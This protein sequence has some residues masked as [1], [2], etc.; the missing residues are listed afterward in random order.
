[1]LLRLGVLSKVVRCGVYLQIST[2]SIQAFQH[3]IDFRKRSD[4]AGLSAMAKQCT[5]TRAY[6]CQVKSIVLDGTE[7]V[8]DCTVHVAHAYDAN[9]FVSH[10]CGEQFLHDGDVCNL[11]AI[12]LER[13]IRDDAI[14]GYDFFSDPN[15]TGPGKGD[16]VWGKRDGAAWQ[17]TAPFFKAI[18]DV[19]ALAAATK[20]AARML[21]NVVDLT[22]FPVDKVNVRSRDTRRIGL[23]IMGLADALMRAMVPYNTQAGRHLVQRMLETMVNAAEE[24]TEQL[25]REKGAFPLFGESAHRS[26][27]PRRNSA[28][29]TV[30]PTGTTSLVFD[31]CGGVEPYFSLHYNYDKNAVLDGKTELSLGMNRHLVRALNDY[32]P[33]LVTEELMRNVRQTGSVLRGV[34][35]ESGMSGL[36]LA[37]RRVFATSM[38][39]APRDHVAMQAALQLYVDNS[40]SKTINLPEE[41]SI[42]DVLDVYVSAWRK[43][44]KGCT[45]YRDNSRVLQVLR[46]GDGSDEA[47]IDPSLQASSSASEEEVEACRL[48]ASANG[49]TP[50]VRCSE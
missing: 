14:R 6:V 36:P 7:D 48:D 10:N 38:D 45:V 49:G 22:N 3:R 43:G 29:L 24:M 9:G 11:G 44:C 15:Y 27:A 1:M 47:P 25:A 2:A 35:W 31:V 5:D 8:Y 42:Q 33:E 13:F 12:N 37:F 16:A 23:G 50:C 19:D 17:A 28:L 41:A 20:T 21:D 39:I 18:L 32:F 34:Y 30:A 26:R 40:M 4:A 46:T